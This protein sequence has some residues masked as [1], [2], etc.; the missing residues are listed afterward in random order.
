MKIEVGKGKEDSSSILIEV[1]TESEVILEVEKHAECGI[2]ASIIIGNSDP[3]CLPDSDKT[4]NSVV[5][6]GGEVLGENS[7]RP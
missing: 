5:R 3:N 6:V 4:L 7:E 1:F 2:T